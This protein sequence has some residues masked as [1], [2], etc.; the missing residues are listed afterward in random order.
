MAEPGHRVAVKKKRQAPA[1]DSAPP[2]KK[3]PGE[4]PASWK[5]TQQQQAFIDSFAQDDDKED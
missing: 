5:L 3:V 1:D 2:R 4:V